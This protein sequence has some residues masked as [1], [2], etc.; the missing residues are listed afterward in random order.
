MFPSSQ[1]TELQSTPEYYDTLLRSVE[2]IMK[3]EEQD[4][5]TLK[6]KDASLTYQGR[7]YAKKS[8]CCKLSLHHVCIQ[9]VPLIQLLGKTKHTTYNGL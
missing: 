9:Y 5:D 6:K 4:D 7:R 1:I 8:K 3:S 2:E